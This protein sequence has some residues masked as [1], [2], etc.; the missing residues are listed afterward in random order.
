M[1]LFRWKSMIIQRAILMRTWFRPRGARQRANR[2]FEIQ[3]ER[4]WSDGRAEEKFRD[5]QHLKR[6]QC[7]LIAIATFR[8]SI[9]RRMSGDKRRPKS[10]DVNNQ[11]RNAS[12]LS[13]RLRRVTVPSRA[14]RRYTRGAIA[15][16][17]YTR[18][19]RPNARQSSLYAR[20]FIA[21]FAFRCDKDNGSREIMPL[22]WHSRASF[23]NCRNYVHKRANMIEIIIFSETLR[24]FPLLYLSC[25]S[26]SPIF[27]LV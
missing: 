16:R 13:L 5:L 23:G 12:D 10:P 11:N 7:V 18:F 20:R 27:C 25:R 2:S 21:D 24:F 4:N 3:I 17:R 14:I 19:R 15:A 9:E 6:A 1:A 26:F 8:R 22:K